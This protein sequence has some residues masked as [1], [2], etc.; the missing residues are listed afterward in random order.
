MQN[1]DIQYRWNK[2]KLKKIQ[3]NVRY[4]IDRSIPKRYTLEVLWAVTKVRTCTN[5]SKKTIVINNIACNRYVWMD[6][7]ADFN[8]FDFLIKLLIGID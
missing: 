3:I 6:K 1:I 4:C 8:K 5:I 2:P 7:E